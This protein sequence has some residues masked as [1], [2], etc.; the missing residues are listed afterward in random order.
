MDGGGDLPLPE[1]DLKRAP[2]TVGRVDDRVR[3]ESR[4]VGLVQ[5]GRACGLRVEAQ[6][7]DHE[8]KK[9]VE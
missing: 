3:L 9:G 8:G 1:P 6:A 5:N 2:A 7:A 4:A